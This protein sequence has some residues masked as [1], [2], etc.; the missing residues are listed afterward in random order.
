MEVCF[1]SEGVPLFGTL[2]TG[3]ENADP[4]TVLMLHGSGPV[5]RNQNMKGQKLD[6]FNHLASEFAK[7]GIGSLRY[8]KRG[9]GKSGGDYYTTGFGDL[10]DD[11]CA[12]VDMLVSKPKTGSIILLGHSEGTMIAPVVAQRR[13][14]V[15][16]MILL[17][18]TVQPVEELL[19]LQAQRFAEMV[20]EMPGIR[21]TVMRLFA[22]FQ[23]G[24]IDGQQRLIA[25]TKSTSRETFYSMGKKVPAKW[26]KELLAH[27]VEGWMRKVDI[28]AL[29]IS[30]AKDIQC[31][32]GDGRRVEELSQGPVDSHCLDDIA[33]VLRTDAEPASFLRYEKIMSNEIDPRI[34]SLCLNWISRQKFDG[35][36]GS[37]R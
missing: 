15:R 8:D 24:V 23:G 11:A 5:D 30:G 26:L 20:E 10:I 13:P 3:I 35:P 16:G 17:C 27:D 21:G 32:P 36:V 2:E 37:N 31:M 22:R 9:C 29:A 1:L 25:K 34:I 18:P 19:L 28:P 12:A 4:V 14:Q 7:A 6:V 33:H